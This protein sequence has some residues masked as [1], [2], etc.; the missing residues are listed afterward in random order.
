MS[1]TSGRYQKQNQSHALF[2]QQAT[3]PLK[4]N[5]KTKFRGFSPQANYTG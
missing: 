2:A 3:M 1:M 5:L 4:L